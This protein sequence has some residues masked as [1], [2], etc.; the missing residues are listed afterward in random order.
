MLVSPSLLDADMEELTKQQE[1][2]RKWSPNN[3]VLSTPLM[4]YFPPGL[5]A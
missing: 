2:E 5:P 4:A 1:A 3:A